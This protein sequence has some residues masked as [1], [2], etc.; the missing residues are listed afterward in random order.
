MFGSDIR[1]AQSIK[2]AARALHTHPLTGWCAKCTVRASPNASLPKAAADAAATPE[3]AT[4]HIGG[5]RGGG[6][7]VDVKIALTYLI[8]RR[9]GREIFNMLKAL[10]FVTVVAVAFGTTA[11][12]SFHERTCMRFKF[13]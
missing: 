8:M 1:K 6:A 3:S 12:P 7:S 11:P 2:H 5:G 4:S 13:I 10:L 9:K